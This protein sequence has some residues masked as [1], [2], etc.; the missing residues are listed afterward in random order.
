MGLNDHR[1]SLLLS[2]LSLLL[3]LV[4][5]GISAAV[6][7]CKLSPFQCQEDGDGEGPIVFYRERVVISLAPGEVAVEGLYFFRNTSSRERRARVYY[8]FPIDEDH[9]YP[10]QVEV[11]GFQFT[12]EERGISWWMDFP[13]CSATTVK[14]RYQQRL[15]MNSA[16]YILTST[17]YWKRPLRRAEFVIKAPLDWQGLT[18]SYSPDRR[19]TK[20]GFVYYYITKTDFMPD[21]DL[22]IRW[23]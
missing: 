19:V 2:W 17:L 9:P 20:G 13:A 15:Y 16:T 18:I 12:R 4:G 14:V 10:D 3:A 5:V 21:R 22:V 1:T 11:E 6:A 8:P 23:P 7:G